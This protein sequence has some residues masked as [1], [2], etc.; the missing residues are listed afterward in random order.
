MV[1]VVVV[2]MMMMMMMM[3]LHFLK[4]CVFKPKE[5]AEVRAMG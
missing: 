5:T 2:M 1:V 3:T 4:V